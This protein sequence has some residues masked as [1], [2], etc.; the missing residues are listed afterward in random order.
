MGKKEKRL[1]ADAIAAIRAHSW[2]GNVRELE[3]AMERA[4]ILARTDEIRAV[5][6]PFARATASSELPT[7]SPT[8]AGPTDAD[9]LELPYAEA[10]RRSLERFEN[11]YLRALTA[12]AGGNTSEAARLAGL[13]RSNFRRIQRRIVR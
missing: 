3:N 2:P 5:D 7:G 1:S 4:C 11:D 10:K 13:D 9:L 12:R 8:P 6:F